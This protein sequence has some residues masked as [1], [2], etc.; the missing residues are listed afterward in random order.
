MKVSYDPRKE[1]EILSLENWDLNESQGTSSAN[2]EEFVLTP[3]Q[4]Y[5]KIPK[6]QVVVSCKRLLMNIRRS[7]RCCWSVCMGQWKE[8]W[9]IKALRLRLRVRDYAKE[10][11][12]KSYDQRDYNVMEWATAR[13][14]ASATLGLPGGALLWATAMYLNRPAFRHY[15][16]SMDIIQHK[17]E[18]YVDRGTS[19][20]QA[21]III[22]KKLIRKPEH[23]WK[24]AWTL[25]CVR[26]VFLLN[27]TLLFCLITMACAVTG[28]NAFWLL[29]QC[30]VLVIGSLIARTVIEQLVMP[31][32]MLPST[33]TISVRRE[34]DDEK[35]I[36]SQVR[37][38]IGSEESSTTEDSLSDYSSANESFLDEDPR[39]TN[40]PSVLG[41]KNAKIIVRPKACRLH[42][43]FKLQQCIPD[44][45]AHLRR[46]K[47]EDPLKHCPLLQ[48]PGA[49]AEQSERWNNCG[50]YALRRERSVAFQPT[51]A[52]D[53]PMKVQKFGL[54]RCNTLSTI[55]AREDY[56][57]RQQH[58]RWDGWFDIFEEK[59]LKGLP[60]LPKTKMKMPDRGLVD[61]FEEQTVFRPNEQELTNKQIFCANPFTDTRLGKTMTR[62]TH[63]V[64]GR[65]APARPKW[66]MSY[67][68]ELARSTDSVAQ[69]I[70]A[71]GLREILDSARKQKDAEA[72]GADN[73]S[74][75][76][77]GS[78]ESRRK[79]GKADP[80]SAPPQKVDKTIIEQV[81][82]T[83]EGDE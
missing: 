57:W 32:L 3:Q 22:M 21:M 75:R 15:D 58:E 12:R 18:E 10:V 62:A 51:E 37:E 53:W 80:P 11:W 56:M 24:K 52:S 38:A 27:V 40:L 72:A 20:K 48:V 71:E 16:D 54:R 29:P 36:M 81:E 35:Y 5:E 63:F 13:T 30:S 82:D 73:T 65:P 50:G 66:E 76:N 8:G 1:K 26:I 79:G 49:Y 31:A 7:L 78:A 70:D 23:R 14:V 25:R 64:L 6:P 77:A 67:D 61:Q 33:T 19:H 59:A 47:R 28:E 44:Y 45:G 17:V 69:F 9:N 34:L 43:R 41:V 60:R 4:L 68:E 83:A 42:M 46:W 2:L 74:L 55:S 39:S